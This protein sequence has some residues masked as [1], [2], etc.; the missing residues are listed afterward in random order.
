MPTPFGVERAGFRITRVP[1]A[2]EM[3]GHMYISRDH[4]PVD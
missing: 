4:V 1:T 3:L 2:A